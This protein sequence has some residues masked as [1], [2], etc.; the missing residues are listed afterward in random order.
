ME[1]VLT[2]TDLPPAGRFLVLVRASH[3]ALCGVSSLGSGDG[4]GVF[5][6][7]AIVFNLAAGTLSVDTSSSRALW[8]PPAVTEPDARKVDPDAMRH[9]FPVMRQVICHGLTGV[10]SVVPYRTT[11]STVPWWRCRVQGDTRAWQLPSARNLD[12]CVRALLHRSQPPPRARP[13]PP[14]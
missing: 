10:L 14:P 13:F 11:E 8:T 12:L 7:T 9:M 2:C 1:L 4:G 6:Q 5:E 3:S